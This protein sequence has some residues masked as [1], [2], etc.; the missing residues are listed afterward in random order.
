MA[1][2][3]LSPLLG[4]LI[5]WPATVQ[6]PDPS[7]VVHSQV[8]ESPEGEVRLNLNGAEGRRTFAGAFLTEGFGAGVGYRSEMGYE[9]RWTIAQNLFQ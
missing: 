3:S 2:L 5:F 7:G 4:P 8:I 1:K 6:L 9:L